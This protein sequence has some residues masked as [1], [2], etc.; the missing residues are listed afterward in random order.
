M[1]AGVLAEITGRKR[2]R[3]FAY[4]GYLRLLRA[5]TELSPD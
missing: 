1:A 4:D 2:D 5:G 3:R